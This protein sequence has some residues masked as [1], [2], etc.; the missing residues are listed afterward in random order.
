MTGS[1]NSWFTRCEGS[2]VG[3]QLSGEVT[4]CLR[5]LR[6]GSTSRDSSRPV[7]LVVESTSVLWSGGRPTSRIFLATPSR[8]YTSIERDETEL[9]LTAGGSP[10][11]RASTTTTSTPRHARSI[12]SVKPTGPAPITITF[13]SVMFACS[14]LYVYRTVYQ[15]DRAGS[16]DG[17]IC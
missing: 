13:D 16:S 7:T 2:G 12:A 15:R 14:E 11:A 6:E 4:P 5:P 10:A 9:H 8:L 1:K 3:H 17:P